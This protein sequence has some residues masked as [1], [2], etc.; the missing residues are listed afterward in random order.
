MEDLEDTQ[1]L[2]KDALPNAAPLDAGDNYS[3][4]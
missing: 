3:R 1:D 2:H 4:Y